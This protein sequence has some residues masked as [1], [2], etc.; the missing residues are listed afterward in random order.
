M[1]ESRNMKIGA[2]CILACLYFLLLPTTIAINSAGN[3]ILKVATIPIGLFFVITI[4]LSKKVLQFNVIHLLLCIFTC[5]TALT[6]FVD[7][8]AGSVINVFGYFLNAALY[9]CLSVVQYN[10]RERKLLEDIQIVLMLILVVI[11]LVSNGSAFNRTTLEIF[12]QTCDPNYFV[13]FFVFPMVITMKKIVHSKYRIAYIL[14]ALLSIYCIFLSGSRGG[15]IAIVASII[16][17]AVIYPPKLKKKIIVLAVGCG[18]IVCAWLAIAP[19]L[20]ENIVERMSV[21]QVIETGGTG[22]WYI[23]KSAL[24]EIVK[25][26]DKL[27]FGRGIS[28]MHLVF[29][30]GRWG[31]VVAHNQAIQILYN[32]GVVGFLAFAALTAGCFLRCIRKR[33]TVSIAL[34]GMLALAISLSFDQ[35]TRTF[36]NI[37]AYAAFNFSEDESHASTEILTLSEDNGL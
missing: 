31:E 9:I 13:G 19:F 12:G 2:H 10:A 26:P 37:V 33:K 7:A 29:I 11:T 28:A 21:S 14:L 16:A 34:I 8:S 4:L 22:R 5:S 30:N 3:S 25:S 15:L 1:H 35:T 18:F 6:L 24:N 36:W 32:Q 27:L 23:W 17:F 20:P